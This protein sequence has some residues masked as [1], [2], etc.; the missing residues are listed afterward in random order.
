MTTQRI[1]PDPSLSFLAMTPRP[2]YRTR[3]IIAGITLLVG[4]AG[5]TLLP[6]ENLRAG[7]TI[8]ILVAS[9]STVPMALMRLRKEPPRS[10]E[11]AY[12][13]YADISMVAVI[14]MFDSTFLAMPA[15][16]VFVLVS[17]FAT[18]FAEVR[19]LAIHVTLSLVVLIVLG[20]FALG[21]GFEVWLVVSRALALA[22]MFA[23]PFVIRMYVSYMRQQVDAAQ[24]DPDTGLLTRRGL[25]NRVT[26]LSQSHPNTTRTL[27]ATVVEISNF[28][29]VDVRFGRGTGDDVT[30]E[31]VERLTSSLSDDALIARL[32][33]SE[34]LC[35]ILVGDVESANTSIR[36]LDSTLESTRLRSAP[37]TLMTGSAIEPLDPRADAGAVLHQ[38]MTRAEASLHRRHALRQVGTSGRQEA[39][40]RISALIDAGGPDIVFQP[41]CSTATGAVVGYEALSR[42]PAGHGSP[43]TWFADASTVGLRVELEVIAIE[44]AIEASAALPADAF[45][46]VNASA[47][48]ILSSDLARTLVGRSGGRRWIVEVTEHERIEDYD[49][50]S[51]AVEMLRSAGVLI[52]VDDVGSGYSG[53]RQLVELRPGVVKL[54]ASI[55]RGIDKD[56]MRRAAAMSITTFC[57]EIG[58]VSIF[59]G[60]ETEAELACARQVGADMVQG[61][62]LGR[63]GPAQN[64]LSSSA[65]PSS[66][67]PT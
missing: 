19:I 66:A 53:L 23:S 34:F 6:S 54:D 17:L 5:L 40:D 51:V 26:S 62:L 4:M 46:A 55:V 39:H 32:S 14:A 20:A 64:Q 11:I 58:A 63:P 16:S 41:V 21:E 43:Q 8:V 65:S 49:G 52:S 3:V 1:S 22:S 28:A 30:V 56:P 50:M 48:T 59:E 27:A 31:V 60:I 29:D 18:A 37:V 7:G 36:A 45:G 24:R 67:A 38:L 35:L 33:T 2:V 44:A 42:F 61:F 47:D 12:I 13:V 25:Y 9:L 10:A 15:V 57:R